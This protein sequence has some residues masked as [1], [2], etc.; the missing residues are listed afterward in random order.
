MVQRSGSY[1]LWC[2]EL[3]DPPP[4]GPACSSAHNRHGPR[5]CPAEI[6]KYKTKLA[7]GN[8]MLGWG[9]GAPVSSRI[10]LA[11]T[12]LPDSRNVSLRSC[13]LTFQA[14]LPT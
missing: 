1:L 8:R 13:Q 14:R 9:A 5:L 10:T 6:V 3:H 4:F 2:F 11:Y 12:T 7:A